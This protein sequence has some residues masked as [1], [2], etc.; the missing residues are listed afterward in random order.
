MSKK[1]DETVVQLSNNLD[2]RVAL[3]EQNSITTKEILERME[4]RF[5]KIDLSILELSN[6]MD[7]KFEKVDKEAKSNFRW[8]LSAIVA[9][10]A[11]I[12]HGFHWF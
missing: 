4:R 9:L 1:S 10:G 7:N 2:I 8:L 12:A 6:R 3:L 5:D 11:V